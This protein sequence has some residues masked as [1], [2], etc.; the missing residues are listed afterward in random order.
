MHEVGERDHSIWGDTDAE[1]EHYWERAYAAAQWLHDAPLPVS[2]KMWEVAIRCPVRGCEL[3]GVYRLPLRDDHDG[4]S[5][6][7]FLAYTRRSTSYGFLNWPLSMNP[8]GPPMHW[9]ATGCPH[10]QAKLDLMWMR[11][12]VNLVNCPP[13]D[14][15]D[16]KAAFAD[17]S[18]TTR[19][20]VAR[21]TFHPPAETWRAKR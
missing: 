17:E 19:Y 14:L 10:G 5:R 12:A 1:R 8:D 16:L 15:E 13:E 2:N 6:F 18:P 4:G 9:V 3:A 11:W 20:S 21:Q 7:I